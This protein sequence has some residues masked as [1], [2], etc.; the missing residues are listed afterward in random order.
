VKRKKGQ[1]PREKKNAQESI[2][3][4]PHRRFAEIDSPGIASVV[5]IYCERRMSAVHYHGNAKQTALRI[6]HHDATM[7]ID[8]ASREIKKPRVG[9]SEK[10]AWRWTFAN[11]MGVTS[12]QDHGPSSRDQVYS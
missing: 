9:S 8:H 11:K 5:R 4:K 1:N 6:E 7:G 3:A 2:W 12:Q 10:R